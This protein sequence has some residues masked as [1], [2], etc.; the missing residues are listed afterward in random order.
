MCTVVKKAPAYRTTGRRLKPHLM[1]PG[2]SKQNLSAFMG[3]KKKK[4]SSLASKSDKTEV[5]AKW[6]KGLDQ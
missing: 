6:D 4:S 3:S 1:G 5:D 2:Y